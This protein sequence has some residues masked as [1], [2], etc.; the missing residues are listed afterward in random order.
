MNVVIAS[1]SPRFEEW[2]ESHQNSE[3]SVLWTGLSVHL[4]LLLFTAFMMMLSCGYKLDNHVVLVFTAFFQCRVLWCIKNLSVINFLEE[5]GVSADQS[6]W[7]EKK[8]YIRTV[9]TNASC[10]AFYWAVWLVTA[11][12]I[13][14][15]YC[16]FW[17]RQDQSQPVMSSE[18]VL[19]FSV[20]GEGVWRETC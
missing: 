1:I 12:L 3:C 2:K 11:G 5:S 14:I 20:C 7:W 15:Y 19:P 8:C 18:L 6:T 17:D 9:E 13:I 10:D 4:I 16:H